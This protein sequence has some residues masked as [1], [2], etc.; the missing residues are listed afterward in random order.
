[1]RLAFSN[2][3]E[4]RDHIAE[5]EADFARGFTEHLIGYSLGRPFGFID[6]DLAAKILASA[7]LQDDV[8]SAFIRAL[9]S[10][11]EFKLK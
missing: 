9:V 1:V 3:N 2:F 6:E 7:K 4:L 8:I 10:S 11:N 5:R